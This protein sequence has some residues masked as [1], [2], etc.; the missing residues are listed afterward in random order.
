MISPSVLHLQSIFWI[1]CSFNDLRKSRI[2]AILNELSSTER[3]KSY[4]VLVVISRYRFVRDRRL[5][6]CIFNDATE[7]LKVKAREGEGFKIK[8]A[9]VELNR[10]LMEKT[11]GWMNG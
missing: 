9:E 5:E 8:G 1:L 2:V 11:L 4:R 6:V 7:V 3:K 10:R